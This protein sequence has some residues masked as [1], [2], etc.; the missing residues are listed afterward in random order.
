M[1]NGLYSPVPRALR[2][3]RRT[4]R[5]IMTDIADTRSQDARLNL[6]LDAQ[7][8]NLEITKMEGEAD[9]VKF[10]ADDAFRKS[11]LAETTRH[12]QAM[13]GIGAAGLDPTVLGK[14]DSMRNWIMKYPGI[15][16]AMKQVAIKNMPE[17]ELDQAMTGH[18]AKRLFDTISENPGFFYRNLKGL[19]IDKLEGV[20]GDIQN[21]ESGLS[22]EELK[23][24]YDEQYLPLHE[25]L[26]DL[27]MVLGTSE[28]IKPE[29]MEAIQ[30]MAMKY[31]EASDGT[32]ELPEATETTLEAVRQIRKAVYGGKAFPKTLKEMLS[33]EPAG[34]VAT[35]DDKGSWKT[36]DT[37]RIEK[38]TKKKT[39]T[40]KKKKKTTS[41]QD[42]TDPG[43]RRRRG[44][45]R[46]VKTGAEEAGRFLRRK[47]PQLSDVI[48]SGQRG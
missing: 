44:L 28:E 33:G 41:L 11:Q 31:V 46:V 17:E 36:H 23:G 12:H 7:K 1:S 10:K 48:S 45:K 40:P 3:S 16:S 35:G 13:E 15:S 8:G 19:V 22:E 27:D 25:Q 29:D 6:A 14:S 43:A 9:L 30:E 4:L 24:L 42:L 18:E 21:P 38:E 5:D 2:S 26:K 37:G 20:M 34:E 32:L 39:E 47:Q